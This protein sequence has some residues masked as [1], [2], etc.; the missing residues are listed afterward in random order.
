METVKRA[1]PVPIIRSPHRVCP[2]I[3]DREMETDPAVVVRLVLR[4]HVNFLSFLSLDRRERNL[5]QSPEKL[6][7]FPV[8]TAV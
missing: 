7:A 3:A 4:L 8:R 2:P 1:K 5:V 6:I